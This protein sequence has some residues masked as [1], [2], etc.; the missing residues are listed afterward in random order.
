M[1]EATS[2]GA[3]PSEGPL[4]R[5]FRRGNREAST[6]SEY[7]KMQ[8]IQMCGRLNAK[9]EDM[10]VQQWNLLGIGDQNS[11]DRCERK[12]EKYEQ[13]LEIAEHRRD[14]PDVDPSDV[15]FRNPVPGRNE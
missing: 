11:A 10:N 9:I 5:T 7:I 12:Q 8:A 4:N 1:L 14:N 13:L 2:E 3:K 15:R 6:G